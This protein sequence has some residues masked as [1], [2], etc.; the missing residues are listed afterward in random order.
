MRW[1]PQHL[2]SDTEF[3]A[4]AVKAI[5]RAVWPHLWPWLAAAAFLALTS[6]WSFVR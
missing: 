4:V 6:E 3:M 5:A 1:D 2:E